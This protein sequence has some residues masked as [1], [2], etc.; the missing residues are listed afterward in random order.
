[1]DPDTPSPFVV[2]PKDARPVLPQRTILLIEDD[3][4]TRRT[5]AELLIDEGFQVVCAA[6][7]AE[8]VGVLHS[9]PVKPALIILDIWMPFMDG[10]EFRAIQR[11]LP[12]VK[13]IPVVVMT[14]GGFRPEV[15]EGLGLSRVLRK[16]I[17]ESE[18][19]EAVRQLAS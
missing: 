16:P 9:S 7:G 17:H 18:L 3:F 8:A 2:S 1:M 14:A 11:S 4:A 10:I 13:D 15:A 19:L 6:N 5:I 12:S